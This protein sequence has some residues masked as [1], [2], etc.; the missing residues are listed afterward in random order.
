[1]APRKAPPLERQGYHHG[2]LKE[3]LVAAARKLIAERGPAGFALSEAARL[4][5]VSAAAPYRHFKDRDALIA[6]VAERGFAEFGR[7]LGAAWT[8]AEAEPKIGFARMG[9]AYLA[10]AREE[11][12]YYGAMFTGGGGRSRS[13]TARLRDIRRAR[14]RDRAHRRGAGES[15]CAAGGRPARPRLSGLGDVA[16]HCD[17]LGRGTHPARGERRAPGDAAAQRRRRAAGGILGRA[18]RFFGLGQSQASHGRAV[19]ART[20]APDS[21]RSRNGHTDSANRSTRVR[22]GFCHPCFVVGFPRASY[23]R[24][25]VRIRRVLVLSV[26]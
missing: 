17:A 14:K 24:K 10:F 15:R 11:P 4:A 2:N 7:R 19:I 18:G 22:R 20:L 8:G 1:M 5:G 26:T 13:P 25:S 16:W 12:G 9:E 21:S 6:E 3:A 23:K